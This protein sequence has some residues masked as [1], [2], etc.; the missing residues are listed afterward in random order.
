MVTYTKISPKNGE[1][2]RYSWGT[3]KKKKKK[4]KE[5]SKLLLLT[6]SVE[7]WKKRKEE[8]CTHTT[9][10]SPSTWRSS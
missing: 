7:R 6:P 8:Q 4:K 2:Q 9:W 3:Q 1:P 5:V 10:N